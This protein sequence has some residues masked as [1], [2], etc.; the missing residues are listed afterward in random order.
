[1][2]QRG[3]RDQDVQEV[4]DRNTPTS[5]HGNRSVKTPGLIGLALAWEAG[6][7]VSRPEAEV[8]EIW[9]RGMLGLLA[10]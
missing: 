5:P 9:G 6:R 3:W 10:L 7:A 8:L 1:M 2:G 4:R